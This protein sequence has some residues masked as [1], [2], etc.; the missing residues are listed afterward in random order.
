MRICGELR[1]TLDIALC[2]LIKIGH[3]GMKRMSTKVLQIA[4][5]YSEL[6]G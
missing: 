5:I 4:E 3:S 1:R 2:L 6:A